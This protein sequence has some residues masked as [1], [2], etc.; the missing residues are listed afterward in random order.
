MMLHRAKARKVTDCLKLFIVHPPIYSS[1]RRRKRPHS[2]GAGPDL[3][4]RI[5]NL[6][7][8]QPTDL[9]LLLDRFHFTR[10]YGK[11]NSWRSA[12]ESLI[13]CAVP[14]MGSSSIHVSA[15]QGVAMIVIRNV[16]RL[17][18][19]KAKEALPLFKET[20]A[21]QKRAGAPFTARILTDLTGPFYTVVLELTVA[22]VSAWESE[23]PKFMADKEFQ[24]NY[25]KL[26]PLV[27]SGYRELLTVVE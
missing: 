19:G 5:L 4:G 11:V 7:S 12:I 14:E 2:N 23:A 3:F 6:K 27:E 9:S 10:S 21:I 15:R 16:F 22:S 17:K 25:Q 1:G 13:Y 8:N 20:V 26:T 24:A 18:F